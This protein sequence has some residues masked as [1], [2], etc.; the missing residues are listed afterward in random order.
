MAIS[1]LLC[2]VSLGLAF[3]SGKGRFRRPRQWFEVAVVGNGLWFGLQN[4]WLVPLG[5]AACF[6]CAREALLCKR[7]GGLTRHPG[8][9]GADA[10]A[11]TIFHPCAIILLVWDTYFVVV[12]VL[13]VRPVDYKDIFLLTFDLK[14]LELF[15]CRLYLSLY[16]KFIL[17]QN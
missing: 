14:K 6:V 11:V 17:F 12:F 13:L 8:K 16:L 9:Q 4:E 2:I 5:A 7:R 3:T 1:L 10:G 15:A